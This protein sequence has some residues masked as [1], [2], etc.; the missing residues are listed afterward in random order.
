MATFQS[1]TKNRSISTSK[2]TSTPISIVEF[3]IPEHEDLDTHHTSQSLSSITEPS[4]SSIHHFELHGNDSPSL[5][6]ISPRK[7]AK[8]SPKKTNKYYKNL[9]NTSKARPNIEIHAKRRY[10]LD[11]GRCGT[12]QFI[13]QTSFA[14]GV[15]VGMVLDNF[16][17]SSTLSSGNT[18]GT[19]YGKKYFQ[20][21]AGKGLFVRPSKIV[22]ALGSI[23]KSTYSAYTRTRAKSANKK[24]KI[25]ASKTTNLST[26]HNKSIS[27]DAAPTVSALSMST[28]SPL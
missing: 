26:T 19:I 15:W 1:I 24:T 13:G 16:N 10:K 14:K 23:Y 7:S 9:T 17:S 27:S 22:Q 21:R 4:T 2:S 18:N 28:S 11:D 8:K 12:C 3:P 5:N 6:T 20:C 25:K